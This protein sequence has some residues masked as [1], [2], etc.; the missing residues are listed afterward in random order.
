MPRQAASSMEDAFL[1]TI[2][3][4][5]DDDMPRLVFADWLEEHGN[6]RG[7][8]IRLQCQRAKL[9]QHDPHWKA[10]LSEESALLKQFEAEWSKP[11]LR[12]V[13]AVQYRRGFVEHVRVSA[14][15]LLKSAERLFRA[16]PVCSIRLER[17]DRLGEIAD[18]AWLMRVTELDL[19]RELFGS[20][21]LQTLIRSEHCRSLRVLR[22]DRCALQV[23]SI[24]M[25]AS[26]PNLHALQT[27][28]LTGNALTEETAASLVNSPHL[29]SL[30]ELNLSDNQLESAGAI[31]LSASP[32]FQLARLSLANNRIG[33]EGLGAIARCP[34]LAHL[35]YLDLEKN[36]I[37]NLGLEALIQSPHI[38]QLEYLNLA[39][40]HISTR[41]VQLLTD[42]PLL[43]GL[44]Y[45]NLRNNEIDKAT[46]LTVPQ[47]LRTPKMRELLF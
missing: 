29:T 39:Q 21:S 13:E 30:R 16:T 28:T 41:G 38:G 23:A 1:Q 35:Q 9:T 25:L 18:C 7:A 8:F 20:R 12:Y 45:L 22:L 42:S 44:S 15:K 17:V 43:A 33:N 36:A 4:N 10:M 11:I 40:N 31:A 2:L 24:Q 14:T 26:A 32:T 19:N 3:D 37:A 6:P 46:A 47:R 27:L 34:Q 5:P